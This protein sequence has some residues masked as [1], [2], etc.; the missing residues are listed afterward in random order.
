MAGLRRANDDRMGAVQTH[1]KKRIE[2]VIEAPLQNRLTT[3]LEG[4]HVRGFTVMPALAG[5]GEKG[6]W[7]RAG[8]VSDAGRMVVVVCIVDPKHADETVESIY[9]LL[10]RQIGIVTVSDVEV[11][12][13]EKF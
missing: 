12:R 11:V 10:A 9:G 6:S 1:P 2:I 7:Q 13:T 3:L 8:Q 5:H 4:S